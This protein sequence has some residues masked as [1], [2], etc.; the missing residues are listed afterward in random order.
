MSQAVESKLSVEDYQL[1]EANQLG[2]PLGV[3]RLKAGYIRLFTGAA[4]SPS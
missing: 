3:Y 1:I 4:C 2:I